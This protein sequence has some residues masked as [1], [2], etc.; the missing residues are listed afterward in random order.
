MVSL[1]EKCKICSGCDVYPVEEESSVDARSDAELVEEVRKRPSAYR[2][3][4]HRYWQR[5]NALLRRVTGCAHTADDLSQETF[6]KAYQALDRL[7]DPAKFGGWLRPIALRSA[8]DW[9]RRQT[10]RPSVSLCHLTELRGEGFP[11]PKCQAPAQPLESREGLE[12][13][14]AGLTPVNREVLE[15]RFREGLSYAEIAARL[16]IPEGT[17]AARLHRALAILKNRPRPAALASHF[18]GER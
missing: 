17:A 2:H 6:I 12:S 5:V 13:L 15:L 11:D 9:F 3:L 8:K 18:A 14:L 7:R 1:R 4:V 10:R 16:A